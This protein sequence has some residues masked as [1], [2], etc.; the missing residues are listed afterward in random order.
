MRKKRRRR[1]WGRDGKTN[2]DE[3]GAKALDL[4]D[5]RGDDGLRS[6]HLLLLVVERLAGCKRLLYLQDAVVL[7]PQR[8]KALRD[9]TKNRPVG[10]LNSRRGGGVGGRGGAGGVGSHGRGLGF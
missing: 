8:A 3:R 10:G 2:L 9:H 6:E 1:A 7:L 5:R 4:V